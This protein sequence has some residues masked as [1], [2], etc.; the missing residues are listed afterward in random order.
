MADTSATPYMDELAERAITHLRA[1]GPIDTTLHTR[2]T[3]VA[4]RFTR[5]AD[6]NRVAAESTH[7]VVSLPPHREQAALIEVDAT[8]V[9]WFELV[10]RM[11]TALLPPLAPVGAPV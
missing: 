3:V 7:Y 11:V 4:S 10:H 5:E 9:M 1:M 8:T 6:H 2:I